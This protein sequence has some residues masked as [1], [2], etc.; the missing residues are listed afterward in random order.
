[1]KPMAPSKVPVAKAAKGGLV[2]AMPKA[3][4]R[5]KTPNVPLPSK[6]NQG[7]A[8]SENKRT[9]QSVRAFGKQQR[10]VRKAMGAQAGNPQQRAGLPTQPMAGNAFGSM[11]QTPDASSIAGSEDATY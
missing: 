11:P 9:N 1:M 7:P 3:L 8:A 4:A 5:P 2:P 10:R 6:A